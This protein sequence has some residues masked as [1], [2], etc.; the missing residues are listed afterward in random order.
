MVLQ[1]HALNVSAAGLARGVVLCLLFALCFA[2]DA[3]AQ[4]SSSREYNIPPG[5]LDQSLR[6]FASEA[7]I[8]LSFTPAL[9]DGQ[10]S[11]GL[12]GVASVLEGLT[13]LLRDSEL[14]VVPSNGGYRVAAVNPPAQR[15]LFLQPIT[16]K[17][18]LIERDLQDTQTSVS[19]V[20]GEMLDRGG[21]KN[22]LDI[23]ERIPN[24][25]LRGFGQGFAIRGITDGG[26]GGAGQAQAISYQVDGAP[27]TANAPLRTGPLATWDLQQVEVLRGPQST[28]QGPNSLAGAIVIRSQDPTFEREF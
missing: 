7:G 26:P 17:G 19:V 2:V 21:E 25:N 10:Q 18:E 8:T 16:V 14:T 13:Q 22:W 4:S 23:A 1:L 27:L 6:Q 11:P 24:F 9:V 20:T 28:Q 5:P 3:A 15:A 12:R